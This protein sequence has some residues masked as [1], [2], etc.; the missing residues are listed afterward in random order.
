[1]CINDCEERRKGANA[2]D[3]LKFKQMPLPHFWLKVVCKKGWGDIFS[4]A[5]GNI[6][7]KEIAIALPSFFQHRREQNCVFNALSRPGSIAT[8]PG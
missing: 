3:K 5:Y 8:I 7:L 2:L 4:G 6:D 1:M